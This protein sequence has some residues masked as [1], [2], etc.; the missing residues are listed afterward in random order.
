MY[1]C[2]FLFPFSSYFSY[3]KS[4][5][6]Y[7]LKCQLC[8]VKTKLSNLFYHHFFCH[9]K[10]NPNK[11]VVYGEEQIRVLVRISK[12]LKMSTRLDGPQK[13][14]VGWRDYLN[15]KSGSPAS[16]LGSPLHLFQKGKKVLFYPFHVSNGNYIYF[17]LLFCR[18]HAFKRDATIL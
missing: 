2:P 14:Q 10:A 9:I 16:I 3:K 17:F 6:G 8:M 5:E 4:Y 11:P 12:M 7:I 18:L 13:D 15:P 1:K